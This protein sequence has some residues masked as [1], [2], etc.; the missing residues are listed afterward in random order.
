MGMQLE[1][2]VVRSHG[3]ALAH[4]VH[5]GVQAIDCAAA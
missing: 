2:V 1:V 5:P 4:R 3:R